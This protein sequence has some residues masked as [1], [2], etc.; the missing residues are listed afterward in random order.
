ME[1][2]YE[3]KNIDSDDF[4]DILVKI[5]SSFDI[6]FIGDELYHIPNFGALCDHIANKIQLENT[7]DCT[8]QQAFYKLRNAISSSLDVDSKTI[9]PTL[10]LSD[11]FP[12]PTRRTRVKKLENYLIYFDLFLL[13]FPDWVKG[14]LF[15][16]LF[17]SLFVLFFKWQIGLGGLAFS[18]TGYWLAPNISSKLT[19]KTVGQVAEKMAREHYLKSRRN[20][21][22]INKSEIEKFLIDMFSNDLDLDKSKLTREAKFV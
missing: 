15:Q 9:S 6:K 5:E 3:L 19:L 8:T 10:L 17:V 22:T 2:D 13:D 16:V 12:K 11:L 18:L 4:T 7:D 1:K 21:T 14:F 20:P